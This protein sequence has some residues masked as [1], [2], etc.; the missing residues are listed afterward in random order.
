MHVTG[1]GETEHVIGRY[2][3]PAAEHPPHCLRQRLER[4]NAPAAPLDLGEDTLRLERNAHAVHSE[5]RTDCQHRAGNGRMQMKMLVRVDVIER[6]PTRGKTRELRFDLE[7][8][9]LSR[10]L[11]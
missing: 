8:K 4:S 10:P 2:H 11:S 1:P 6:K 7:M 5:S 3:A 9:L